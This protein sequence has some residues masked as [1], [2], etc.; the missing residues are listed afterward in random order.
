MKLT[1]EM[2]MM[3][4]MM[5]VPMIPAMMMAVMIVIM[6]MMMMKTMA[7]MTTP[8]DFKLMLAVARSVVTMARKM[9]P[10]GAC[11]I[12]VSPTY[13]NKTWPSWA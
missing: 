13:V 3:L 1:I 11:Y 12:Q 8:M 7:E 9:S 6:M 2:M 4:T 10:L 5:L